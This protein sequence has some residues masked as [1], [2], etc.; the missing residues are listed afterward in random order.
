MGL[1]RAC[2]GYKPGG[3][4]APLHRFAASKSGALPHLEGGGDVARGSSDPSSWASLSATVQVI[5]G[6]HFSIMTCPGAEQLARR[7]DALLAQSTGDP[8]P[9]DASPVGER[10]AN[11]G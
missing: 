5:E 7:I 9:V 6:D 4:R 1:I 11:N 8:S 3:L 10:P 2:A